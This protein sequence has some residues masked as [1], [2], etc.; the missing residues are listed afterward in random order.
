M[1]SRIVGNH[2]EAVREQLRDQ[3]SFP[4]LEGSGMAMKE[5][6]GLPTAAIDVTDRHTAGVEGPHISPGLRECT[7]REER[8]GC[9]TKN[10]MHGADS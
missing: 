8:A 6:N 10:A 4:I 3:P 2:P 9:R 1:T 5:E 7:G